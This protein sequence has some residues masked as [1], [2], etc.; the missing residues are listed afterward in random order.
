MASSEKL[1][2]DD[3]TYIVMV[4]GGKL[5]GHHTTVVM[6]ETGKTKHGRHYFCSCGSDAGIGYGDRGYD[7]TKG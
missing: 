2:M 5:F 3:I 1:D 6:S 4:S 7:G